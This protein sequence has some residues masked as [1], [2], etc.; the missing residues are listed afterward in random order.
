MLVFTTK[1]PSQN[2]TEQLFQF[3]YATASHSFNKDAICISITWL[4]PNTRKATRLHKHWEKL[5][6]LCNCIVHFDG[7]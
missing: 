2:H 6:S 1:N 3:I 5:Q 4:K 7:A